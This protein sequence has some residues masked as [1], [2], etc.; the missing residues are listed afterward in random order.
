MDA[1]PGKSV[2][3]AIMTVSDTRTEE[4]DKSGKMLV[5]R[6]TAAGHN[7]VD[8]QIVKDEIPIIQAVLKNGLPIARS[9]WSS[10]PAAPG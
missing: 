2:N 9:T 10:P 3:I 4:D 7:V 5:D 1:K 6:A 8:K